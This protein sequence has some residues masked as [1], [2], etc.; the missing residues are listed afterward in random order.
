[1]I[2]NFNAYYCVFMN[3]DNHN[4][5]SN[6]RSKE[7]NDAESVDYEEV[8]PKPKQSETFVSKQHLLSCR[9]YSK[10]PLIPLLTYPKHA[11]YFIDWLHRNMD[12]QTSPREIIKPLR[13][14]CERGLFKSSIPYDI[15]VEEFGGKVAQPWYS[16]LMNE[17]DRYQADE[18]S[19]AL[20][21]L[22]MN[23]F[24]A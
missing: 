1:M 8:N 22:N 12:N 18:L 2:K 11:L 4:N 20:E 21:T 9:D 14:A 23:L 17:R 10:S 16:K 13:A 5:G 15:F 19:L 6:S 24:R 7:S 3:V